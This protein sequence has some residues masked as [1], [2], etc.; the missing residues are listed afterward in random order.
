M[1]ITGMLSVLV[2][3]FLCFQFDIAL[4]YHILVFATQMADDCM[5]LVQKSYTALR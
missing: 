5:V 2:R 4:L 1:V 3:A